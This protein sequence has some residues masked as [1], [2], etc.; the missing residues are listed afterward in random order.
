[1]GTM[2]KWPVQ[3]H[4]EHHKT[5]SKQRRN[6]HK[7]I[8]IFC[9]FRFFWFLFNNNVLCSIGSHYIQ[10]K[11]WSYK[12]SVLWEIMD[13]NVSCLV[14]AGLP[15]A[16]AVRTEA[17][18]VRAQSWRG[19]IP[20]PHLPVSEPPTPGARQ[21]CAVRPNLPAPVGTHVRQTRVYTQTSGWSKGMHMSVMVRCES[22]LLY[23]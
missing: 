18:E 1:M 22:Q 10:W 2:T 6:R 3:K 5:R 14:A 12:L 15:G 21:I 7:E 4:T 8:T 23:C 17:P 19:D 9:V 20:V 13:N 16:A 11:I